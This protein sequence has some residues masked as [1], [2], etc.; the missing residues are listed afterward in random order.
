MRLGWP[1]FVGMLETKV[2]PF[3]EEDIK[4]LKEFG[5]YM[6]DYRTLR[7][8]RMECFDERGMVTVTDQGGGNDKLYNGRN[9]ILTML[10]FFEAENEAFCYRIC[11]EIK[12]VLDE[13]DKLFT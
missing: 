9:F 12:K 8:R 6:S 1:I 10:H 5:H 11:A 2:D 13:Y 7:K 4:I 3:T